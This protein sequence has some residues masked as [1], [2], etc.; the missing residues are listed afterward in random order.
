MEEPV[1]PLGGTAEP[2]RVS[3]GYLCS[4]IGIMVSGKASSQ[5]IVVVIFSSIMK[6]NYGRVHCCD[7]LRRRV[8]CGFTVIFAERPLTVDDK[9]K[10]NKENG[11]KR[12]A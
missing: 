3:E 2:P 5:I 1:R 7:E 9:L 8:H 12:Q 4:L 11:I 10:V 6:G